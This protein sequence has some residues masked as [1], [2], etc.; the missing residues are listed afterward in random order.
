MSFGCGQCDAR[1]TG[2]NTA[3]CMAQGCHQ[4]FTGI[5]AFDAHRTGSHTESG[6]RIVDKGKTEPR[7]PRRC[8]LPADVGLVDAERKYPCWGYPKGDSRFADED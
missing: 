8:L 3:H 1:W 5:T 6:E 2:Q 7:G 4:T